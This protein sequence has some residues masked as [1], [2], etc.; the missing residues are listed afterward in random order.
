M[1]F[2]RHTT[3]VAVPHTAAQIISLLSK[4]GAEQILTDHKAG[5]IVGI[6]FSM[7]MPGMETVARFRLPVYPD[8]VLKAFI[9]AGKRGSDALREQAERTAWRVALE[10]LRAQVAYMETG[11][12]SVVE[13]FLPYLVVNTGETLYKSL[14]GKRFAGL[15][16]APK[17]EMAK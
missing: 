2:Y 5:Q 3:K 14:E 17:Q 6:A 12:V 15:L 8:R 10:W 16:M 11:Q 13:V 4:A 7:A 1:T 9:N